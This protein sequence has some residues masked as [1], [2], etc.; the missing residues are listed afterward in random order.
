MILLLLATVTW[1]S[2]QSQSSVTIAWDANV[3]PEVIGYYVYTG[4]QSTVYSR[5][6]DAGNVTQFRV[7]GLQQAIRYYFAVSAY[8]AGPLEGPR[9]VEISTVLGTDPPPPPDPCPAGAVIFDIGSWTRSIKVG[10]LGMVTYSL[11]R[12]ATV[13][14]T[15]IVKLNGIEQDRLIGNDLKRVAGSYFRVPT[16]PG[17]YSLTVDAFN[18]DGCS[19]TDNRPMTVVVVQ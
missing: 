2:L 4:T 1:L 10:G 9:S 7:E 12:S 6:M 3:E 17:T 13:V 18:A 16:T 14:T 8:A 5:R 19:D 15:V 11:G